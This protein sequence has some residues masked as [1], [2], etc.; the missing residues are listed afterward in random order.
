MAHARVQ[1][2]F[3]SVP[4]FGGEAV[5][6]LRADGEFFGDTDDLLTNVG[7]DIRPILGA[8]EAVRIALGESG[9]S[10]CRFAESALWIVR[11]DAVDHLTYRVDL[12][13]LRSTVPTAPIF[14]L[15][16]RVGK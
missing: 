13:P 8:A 10:G 2:Y 1:Q 7:V 4:V 16:R 3:R 5:V 12:A 14:L 9:C 15:T 11:R 6:H